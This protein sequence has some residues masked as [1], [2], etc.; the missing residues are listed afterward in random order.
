MVLEDCWSNFKTTKIVQWCY[1]VMILL[2]DKQ[3]LAQYRRWMGTGKFMLSNRPFELLLSLLAKVLLHTHTVSNTL[4]VSSL[5]SL[6]LTVELCLSVLYSVTSTHSL[7]WIWLEKFWT[8]AI[9]E[10]LKIITAVTISI[11]GQAQY[12]NNGNKMSPLTCPMRIMNIICLELSKPLEWK[13]A[14]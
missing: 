10:C 12:I 7:L 8:L 13:D 9:L 4:S 5:L 2:P 3:S 14:C 11:L 1:R 6:T